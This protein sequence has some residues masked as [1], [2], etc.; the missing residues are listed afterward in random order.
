MLTSVQVS[1][2][3]DTWLPACYKWIIKPGFERGG[4]ILYFGVHSDII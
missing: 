1:E 2:Q 4:L 3:A